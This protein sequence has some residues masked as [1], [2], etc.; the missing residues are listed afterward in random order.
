MPRIYRR[1]RTRRRTSRRAIRS[2]HRRITR[3]ARMGSQIVWLRR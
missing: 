1:R 2:I 3:V